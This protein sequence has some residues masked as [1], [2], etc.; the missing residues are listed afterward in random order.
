MLKTALLLWFLVPRQVTQG[1]IPHQNDWVPRN[2]IL[3][4]TVLGRWFPWHPIA[5]HDRPQP[6]PGTNQRP[7]QPTTQLEA[8]TSGQWPVARHSS[9]CSPARR[10]RGAVPPLYFAVGSSESILGDSVRV[11]Q[12]AAQGGTDVIIEATGTANGEGPWGRARGQSH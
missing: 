3:H 4:W 5:G 1:I 11:A 8:R 6:V 12:H 2:S 9:S 10:T 7:D